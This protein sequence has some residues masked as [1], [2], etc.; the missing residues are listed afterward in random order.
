M[1]DIYRTLGLLLALGAILIIGYRL[2]VYYAENQPIYDPLTDG[3]EDQRTIAA[4]H[5][6]QLENKRAEAEA[7]AEIHR[8]SKLK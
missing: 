2:I 1:H 3:P 5:C 4:E 6:A 8:V 7:I